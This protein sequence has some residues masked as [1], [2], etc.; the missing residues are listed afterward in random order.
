MAVLESRKVGGGTSSHSTGNLYC[1]VDKNL[2]HLQK[3]HDA[4]V[5]RQVVGS[6]AAAL[7][8]I[9]GWVREFGIDCDFK[10][11]PW[12]LYAASEKN[13]GRIAEEYEHA[14]DA[15]LPVGRVDASAF[16]LDGVTAGMRLER[17]A[18]IN[19]MRYVQGL[20]KAAASDT[21]RIYEC[22]RVTDVVEEEESVTLAT[23]G[24][25]VRA[26]YAIHATHIPK[27][28]KVVQTELSMHREYG[29]A[30]PAGDREF[31]E[32]IFWGYH[33]DGRKFSSRL[34]EREGERF[35]MVIGAEHRVGQ[36]KNNE[37]NIRE[38]EEFA[39]EQY[40]LTETAFRW[41]G[42]HYKPA[43]L[44]PYI[45]PESRGSRVF[46][47][48]GFSTDG[49]VYGTLA[50]MLI[51]D[52]IAEKENEWADLYNAHRFTPLKSAGNIVGQGLNVAKQYL[53]KWT[54]ETV[55]EKD[56]DH[57]PNGE[58]GIVEVEGKTIAAYRDD[59]GALHTL[60]AV[61]PHMKCIV[62]WNRAERTWDCPCHGSR[63][64]TKGEVLEG[65][66]FG[67]MGS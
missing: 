40:G 28:I 23:T 37:E 60:S 64:D 67:G 61:C 9:E 38:L 31:P 48:T 24:G 14:L 44:L 4:D 51:A 47:A 21:C 1:V 17:Q 62:N 42:Q 43:D 55:N 30:C 66:A 39:R 53:K 41:G 56:F 25:M 7:E 36:A 45:G 16:P 52:A 34:Y 54:G 33:D 32:G 15:G 2:G 65:P 26:K 58:G 19:P 29:V 27:G 11:V 35:V 6:R 13:N 5:I 10:R 57:I 3:K 59:S 20:A 8:R 18:Q 12:Y 49:L 63:F 46:V 22:T 50:G